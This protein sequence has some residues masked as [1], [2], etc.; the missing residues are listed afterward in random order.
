MIHIS[1]YTLSAKI[2]ADASK[3]Q[4]AISKAQKALENMQSSVSNAGKVLKDFGSKATEIGG[5][6]TVMETAVSAAAGAFIKSGLDY[7][8][9]MET[10]QTSFEV[11]T[12]S[13]EK[14]IEIT[15]QLSTMGAE[16]PFEMTDLADTT[17]LLMQFGFS[18]EG[19]IESLS[20]LGDI[21]QGS[22]DKMNSIARAYGKMSSSCK[23]SLEDINMMIDAGFNP[24][25]EISDTT[26]ES[27]ASL[28]DRISKGAMSVDEITASMQ[29][30]TSAGGRYFKSME[31][32]S[33]TFAGQMST[34]QDNFSQLIGNL[35]SG[36]SEKIAT[37]ILPVVN[38]LLSALNDGFKTDG[39]QG[40]MDAVKV[41]SPQ[42]ENI[43]EVVE[44]IA[45]KLSDLKQSGV[46]LEKIAL[47]IAG[48]GPSLL[49]MGKLSSIAG[50][51]VQ[52]F[53]MLLSPIGLVAAAVLGVAGGI[54]YLWQ[55]NED[56]RSSAISAWDE[57]Q[58]AVANTREI[59]STVFNSFGEDV[60]EI[61][62]GVSEGAKSPLTAL[63]ETFS[64][65]FENI[66]VSAST[67][68]IALQ[69]QFG[70]L[71]IGDIFADLKESVSGF[72]DDAVQ[73]FPFL[74]S[75]VEKLEQAFATVKTVIEKVWEVAEAFITGFTI[76]VGGNSGEL[77]SFG[78]L[79][80]SVFTG[81]NPAVA[82]LFQTLQ[83]LMPQIGE[84]ITSVGD[85]LG[86]VMFALG[87]TI[88]T[89]T[90]VFSSLCGT[91]IDSLVPVIGSILT[92]VVSIVE[93]V[94]PVVMDTITEL[95]PIISEI[96]IIIG[97]VFEALAPIITSLINSLLPVIQSIVKAVMPIISQI[98]QLI[99]QLLPPIKVIIESII[100]VIQAIMP[101]VEEI[102]E[103]L[104]P[105]LEFVG[106]LI[107]EIIAYISPM[108]VT[109][110]EIVAWIT[111]V[112]GGI[113]EFLT[114]VFLRD[115]KGAWE[116]IKETVA[117]IWE[118]I[119]EAI[120]GVA[121]TIIDGV[122]ALWSG[123]YDAVSGI[124]NSVG[125]VAGAL[126]DLFGMDWSFSMPAEPPLIPYLAHGTDNFQGGFAIMNEGGRG[127][128]VSLPNGA[129]V[130][131]H[132]ISAKYAK[133]AARIDAS[134]TIIFDYTAMG[135]AVAA[136][137]E[138]VDV[139]VTSN[140]NGRVV[141]DEITPLVNQNMGCQQSLDRRHT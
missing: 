73:R 107:G 112:I 89:L 49:V 80:L 84:L 78:S 13:A 121:N 137:M 85:S 77:A 110:T 20:M 69:E 122:N 111:E 55:T 61:W 127:E 66:K 42:A 35:T 100:E 14:A 125:E 27:M 48:L 130:I 1:D 90:V 62:E 21:S 22:A 63:E 52:A 64:L 46:P 74:R 133:E 68:A 24:L 140:I 76:S 75:T 50:V 9:T 106:W 82:V 91:L 11:M 53:S 105:V 108:I 30:S 4:S 86:P 36:L 101:A 39:I 10:Y 2:T 113:I 41:I 104:G 98:V 54:A 134:N 17:Q 95:T 102:L 79:L 33:K 83:E 43:I 94:M 120:K 81:A 25:Q 38:E 115:W 47:A 129:Q 126:G 141:A 56:F 3:F 96:A 57:L 32:Q 23:V 26:G 12:G 70:N 44:D 97:D 15:E 7:N 16:T 119:W 34:L 67:I 59:I 29:R 135:E 58:T 114:D 93:T 109:I 28:Y 128:L 139:R 31:K 131:P 124:V 19:A 88:G 37:E 65:T 72:L 71:S 116:S 60:S 138:H 5:K 92:T 8:A 87:E 99:D 136:A 18:A 103:A 40:M 45:D 132:D 51:A 6:I 117:V 118:G 123:I